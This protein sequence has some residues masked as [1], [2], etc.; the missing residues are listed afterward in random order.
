MPIIC[1]RR[2]TFFI[3]KIK[4]PLK[5]LTLI[6][7]RLFLW[8]F[9]IP[10]TLLSACSANNANAYNYSIQPVSREH[11]KPT[12]KRLNIISSFLI[13]TKTKNSLPVTELSDLAWDEDEQVLYAI[14]DEGFLYHLELIIKNKQL[15]TVN[16]IAAMRLKNKRKKPLKG[17]YKDAEGLSIRNHNNGIRGDS[18]LIISFENKPR[19]AI[20]DTKGQFLNEI[21]VV[22]K[23]QERKSFRGNNK[24]LES[25]TIHPQ[26][27]ILTAAEKP[28][29]EKSLNT[30]TVYS[31]TGK[32][33][34]FAASTVKNS[35]VTAI[36]VLD[37]NK[38]LILERAYNGIFS[39][40]V[41]SLRQL[42][43]QNCG[44]IKHCEIE[45]IAKFDSSDGWILD[46]FEGLTHFRDNQYLMV[47][48]NNN[49]P[50][51]KTILVLFEIFDK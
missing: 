39:P 50:L 28:L 45:L 27:G 49:S 20:H 10:L 2:E 22:K 37:K 24:A 12:F 42:N 16:I 33:W 40:I 31:S 29:K 21:K 7:H 15:Q 34:N 19:I 1:N 11:L 4:L 32:E 51:Q 23:L 26:H 38:I 41:I 35:S 30:Q 9:F 43:L 8:L 18:Q 17:Q 25:V 14:S 13:K 46:N 44:G 6:R 36:E 47:S 5:P 3:K 48:D